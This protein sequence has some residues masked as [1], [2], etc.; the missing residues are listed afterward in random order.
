M[1]DFF[2]DNY[3]ALWSYAFHLSGRRDVADDAVQ[4]ALACFLEQPVPLANA[5]NNLLRSIRRII[6]RQQR[7][8]RRRLLR[9]LPCDVEWSSHSAEEVGVLDVLQSS[10]HPK[11]LPGRVLSLGLQTN[12]QK[13]LMCE[14]LGI[15]PHALRVNLYRLHKRLAA[16]ISQLQKKVEMVFQHWMA[17]ESSAGTQR[18]YEYFEPYLDDPESATRFWRVAAVVIGKE[19]DYYEIDSELGIVEMFAWSPTWLVERLWI[20]FQ[21]HE[22]N[23]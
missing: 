10:S 6:E 22:K 15:T 20:E 3:L 1:E 7:A 5:K 17:H 12:W 14:E 8:A 2:E 21:D 9:T 11:G 16:A 13:E 4:E 23:P 19:V 18:F